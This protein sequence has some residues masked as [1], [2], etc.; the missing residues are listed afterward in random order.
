[1][2][3]AVFTPITSPRESTSGPPELPGLSDA[4]VWITLSISRP[5]FPRSERPSALTTPAVTVLW[6]PSGLP[7]A[8]ASWPATTRCESPSVAGVRSLASMRTTARSL[9]G[10][11][12]TRSA[13]A[14][15]PSFSVISIFFAS[16]TT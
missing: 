4:S 7:S 14:C 9:S 11:S 3:I 13:T 8:I 10:S 6:K 5:D 1:M 15:R 12:P 16:C 2:I